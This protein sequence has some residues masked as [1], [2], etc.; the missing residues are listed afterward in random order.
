MTYSD[1]V[2]WEPVCFIEKN[3][4]NAAAA[5]ERMIHS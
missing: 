5:F 2:H 3:E 4:G 1:R